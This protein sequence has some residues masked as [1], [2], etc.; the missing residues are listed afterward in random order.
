MS[1]IP[2]LAETAQ[3]TL[4]DPNAATWPL[5]T[6]KEWVLE[7]IRDYSMHFQRTEKTTLAAAAHTHTYTL[8]EWVDQVL[9]VEYPT[10]NDPP[11]LLSRLSRGDPRFWGSETYYDIEPSRQAGTGPRIYVSAWTAAGQTFTITYSSSYHDTTGVSIDQE[12]VVIP[13]NHSPLILQY[14][15][16]KALSERLNKEMQD[17]ARDTMYLGQLRNSVTQAR[18]L[19]DKSIKTT[20]A[21]VANS[22]F[23]KRW[24]LDTYDRIY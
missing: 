9:E 2:Q 21:T 7:A 6:I 1:T 11:T 16:W 8:S 19:Y 22:A 3:L 18:A 5:D 23:T 24:Q 10:G 13:D 20:K 17:P 12:K 14:V 4:A 15:T